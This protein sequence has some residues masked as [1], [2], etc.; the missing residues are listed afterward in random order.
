M[1]LSCTDILRCNFVGNVRVEDAI[2][3]LLVT[4]SLRN[5]RKPSPPPFSH[6]TIQETTAPADSRDPEAQWHA[7]VLRQRIAGVSRAVEKK[8][9]WRSAV[10]VNDEVNIDVDVGPWSPS[11]GVL[12]LNMVKSALVV[13]LEEVKGGKIE[14]LQ[15]CLQRVTAR[16]RDLVDTIGHPL[17]LCLRFC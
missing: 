17:Y 9:G 1:P 14:Y 16:R 3:F 8:G 5:P 11:D 2:L 12:M 13:Q 7:D 6:G 10:L 4:R 15:A